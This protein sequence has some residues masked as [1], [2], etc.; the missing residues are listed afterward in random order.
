M[1]IFSQELKIKSEEDDNFFL[2]TIL[3]HQFK[4]RK[5][6]NLIKT[7]EHEFEIL[8]STPITQQELIIKFF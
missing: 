4:R 1:R 6:I 5:K 8:K 2:I 7:L 3:F